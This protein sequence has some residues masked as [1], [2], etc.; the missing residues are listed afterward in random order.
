MTMTLEL[1]RLTLIVKIDR[2][3][4]YAVLIPHWGTPAIHMT[5]PQLIAAL[6]EI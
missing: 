1:E 5:I 3:V 4:S 2:V 6:K